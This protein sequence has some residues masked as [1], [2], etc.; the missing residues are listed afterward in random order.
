MPLWK[1]TVQLSIP[2]ATPS[3]CPLKLRKMMLRVGLMGLSSIREGGGW[4]GR[5]DV[6]RVKRDTTDT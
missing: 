3:F 1:Q 6:S 4:G 2:I 5:G